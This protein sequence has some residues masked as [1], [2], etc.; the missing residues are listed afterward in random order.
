M[1]ALEYQKFLADFDEK[2]AFHTMQAKTVEH[3]R[4]KFVRDVLTAT[5]AD[6]SKKPEEKG[7]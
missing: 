4:S 6:R 2:I 1:E 7:K 3:E 5:I